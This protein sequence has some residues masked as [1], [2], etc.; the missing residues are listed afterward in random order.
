MF[1]LGSLSDQAILERIK[2]GDESV[3]ILLY[4][5]HYGMVKNFI[6]KN[7]GDE[8]VV[9]DIMQE[10]IVRVLRLRVRFNRFQ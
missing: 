4:R 1:G 3:L 7:N 8:S 9:D 5:K 10:D 6:L 2:Q